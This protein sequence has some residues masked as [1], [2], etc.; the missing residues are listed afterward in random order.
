MLTRLASRSPSLLP[1]RTSK[2]LVMINA[3]RFA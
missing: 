1:L 2:V 3:P